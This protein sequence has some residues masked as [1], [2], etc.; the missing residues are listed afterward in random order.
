MG[1]LIVKIDKIVIVALEIIEK[2]IKNVFVKIIIM[3]VYI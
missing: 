2:F 3:I 1:A